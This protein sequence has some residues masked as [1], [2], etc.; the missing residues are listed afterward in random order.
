MEE[1][2]EAKVLQAI[3]EVAVDNHLTCAEAWQLAEAL[4]VPL[5]VIGRAANQLRVKIRECQL[6]CFK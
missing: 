3:S 2:I 4:G 6:G 5:S 1:P